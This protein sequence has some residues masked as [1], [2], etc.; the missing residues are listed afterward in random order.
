MNK[1][2]MKKLD[3]LCLIDCVIRDSERVICVQ[4]QLAVALDVHGAAGGRPRGVCLRV[5]RVPAAHQAVDEMSLRARTP[6]PLP[7]PPYD[8][9][10][11]TLRHRLRFSRKLINDKVFYI[12]SPCDTVAR[13]RGGHFSLKMVTKMLKYRLKNDK[14]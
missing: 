7:E 6:R 11:I 4:R 14:R 2:V 12:L 3:L 9:T 1:A 10:Y 5:L 13:A 8:I